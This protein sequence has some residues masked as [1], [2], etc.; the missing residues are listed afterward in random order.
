VSR[1]PSRCVVDTSV[2]PLWSAIRHSCWFLSPKYIGFHLVVIFLCSFRLLFSCNFLLPF[3][4]SISFLPGAY[5]K[6]YHQSSYHSPVANEISFA[7]F[8]CERFL[9]PCELNVLRGS[10]SGRRIFRCGHP[11]LVPGCGGYGSLI[12]DSTGNILSYHL[13]GTSMFRPVA[14]QADRGAGGSAALQV[15]SCSQPLAQPGDTQLT[16]SY[17]KITE[18]NRRINLRTKFMRLPI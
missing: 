7:G 6:F 5:I 2:D 16:V 4:L 9:Y 17:E 18:I 13:P 10:A 12:L 11:H 15:T 8:L 14:Q 1:T 3:S